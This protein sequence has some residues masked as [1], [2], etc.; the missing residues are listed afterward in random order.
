MAELRRVCVFAGSSSGNRLDYTEAARALGAELARRGLG[1]VYGGSNVGLMGVAANAALAAGGEVYGVLPRGLF[2]QEVAHTGLTR[3]YEVGSMHE[4]K[5][6]MAD[7]ADGFIALPGGF[8]TLDELF[9]IVTW[10]QIGLH[11]KPVGLLDV[12]GYF[13][14]LLAFVSHATQAGFIPAT[15]EALLLRDAGPAR[16]LDRMERY[17]SPR[18]G[19]KEMLPPPVDR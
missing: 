15:H 3:L 8:G 1:L 17:T 5:A 13:D 10:A 2:R 19:T 14:L 11:T 18:G 12:D 9:E 4:R 6:L 7:L 16:L